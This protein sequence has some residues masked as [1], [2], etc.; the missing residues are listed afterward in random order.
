MSEKRL[1]EHIKSRLSD[2][3]IVDF[4]KYSISCDE[5]YF[6]ESNHPSLPS[7]YK[8]ELSFGGETSLIVPFSCNDSNDF[9]DSYNIKYFSLIQS[10]MPAE[11]NRQLLVEVEFHNKEIEFFANAIE[12]RGRLSENLM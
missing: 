5:I 8:T 4:G 6:Q 9:Q 3:I 1:S 12:K 10:I 2:K 11:S 7:E